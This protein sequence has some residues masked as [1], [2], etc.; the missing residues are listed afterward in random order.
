[1]VCSGAVIRGATVEGSVISPG[2]VIHPG[3][4]VER[5]VLLHDVVVGPGAVVRNCILDKSVEVPPGNKIGVDDDADRKRFTMSD[6][7]IVVIGKD[8]KI[9]T[10]TNNGS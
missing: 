1:M 5:S 2:V 4:I 6:N 3:A 9:P 10:D 8:E 7:G